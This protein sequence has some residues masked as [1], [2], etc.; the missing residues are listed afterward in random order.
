[1]QAVA[2]H[3]K[4]SKAAGLQAFAVTG[5]H[6]KE[7]PHIRYLEPSSGRGWLRGIV[8]GITGGS[9]RQPWQFPYPEISLSASG[10]QEKGEVI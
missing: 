2:T 9:L 4:S 10:S 3:S 6:A 8:S 1:M 5:A 7:N